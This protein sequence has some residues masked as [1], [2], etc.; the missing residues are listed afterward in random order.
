MENQINEEAI[1]AT[2]EL[3]EKPKRRS[4]RSSK[5]IEE[6]IVEK[7]VEVEES[8]FHYGAFE[9]AKEE[10]VVEPEPV[11]EVTPEPEPTPEPVAEVAPRRPRKKPLIRPMRQRAKNPG[12]P[13]RGQRKA[14]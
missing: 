7:T 9:E 10:K 6:P 5:K 12:P 4:R 8:P 14:V 13:G 11:A 3:K 1:E 2:P